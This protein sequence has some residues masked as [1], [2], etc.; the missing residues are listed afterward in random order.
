M[1]PRALEYDVN[2]VRSIYALRHGKTPARLED[3]GVILVTS[4]SALARAT[5]EYGREHESSRAVS[6]VMTHFS[7]AN[8]AWLKAPLKAPDLPELEVI[9]ACY[10]ALEPAPPLW[11]RYAN[12]IDKLRALGGMSA[13]DHQLLRPADGANEVDESDWRFRARVLRYDDRRD[14]DLHEG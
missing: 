2:S 8:V 10:A 3:A 9:A 1:N 12:E 14:F 13:D 7:L 11:N 6:A 5:F 4:N